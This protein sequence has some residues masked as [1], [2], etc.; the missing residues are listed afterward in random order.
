ML[1]QPLPLDLTSLNL[2]ALEAGW[3]SWPFCL[4]YGNR[5]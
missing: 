4:W 5:W 3:F 1:Q 2:H